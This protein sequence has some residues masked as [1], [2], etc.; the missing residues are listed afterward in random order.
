MNTLYLK[1]ALEVEK[2]DRALLGEMYGSLPRIFT[3]KQLGAL[4]SVLSELKRKDRK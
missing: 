3:I 2:T 4:A 1:Y